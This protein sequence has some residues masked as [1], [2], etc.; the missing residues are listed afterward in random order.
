VLLATTITGNS[1]WAPLK[2]S[3]CLLSRKGLDLIDQ[4]RQQ[5]IF[6]GAQSELPV[7]VVAKSTQVAVLGDHHR[8]VRA[9]RQSH[10]RG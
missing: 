3:Y 9:Q 4:G 10:S 2:I 5:L 1:D 8:E 7:M 6:S